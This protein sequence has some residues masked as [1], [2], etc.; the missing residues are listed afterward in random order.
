MLDPHWIF[1]PQKLPLGLKSNLKDLK[2]S[3]MP[4]LERANL[5][6]MKFTKMDEVCFCC[7]VVG[8]KKII[9]NSLYVFK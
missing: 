5:Y 9:V 8:K 1:D 4:I 6:G 7:N 2:N 3:F